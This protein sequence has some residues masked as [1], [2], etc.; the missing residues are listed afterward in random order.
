MKVHSIEWKKYFG[1]CSDRSN[2]M[3]GKHSGVVA[4]IKEVAPNG[5]FV[6]IERL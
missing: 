6:H 2:A 4:Q 1:I 5:K 3:K